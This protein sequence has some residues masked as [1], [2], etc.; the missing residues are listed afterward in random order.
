MGRKN[1]SDTD[2]F[3]QERIDMF[4]ACG[5]MQQQMGMPFKTIDKNYF[6]HTAE[7]LNAKFIGKV[8]SWL[9]DLFTWDVFKIFKSLEL[10]VLYSF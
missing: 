9:N 1:A 8:E 7:V 5:K 10:Q 4:R 6:D 2:S 3:T